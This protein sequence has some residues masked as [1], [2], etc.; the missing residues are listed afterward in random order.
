MPSQKYHHRPEA[1]S[2]SRGRCRLLLRGRNCYC[3]VIFQK[4]LFSPKSRTLCSAGQVNKRAY[5]WLIMW[6]A[7]SAVGRAAISKEICRRASARVDSASVFEL[8]RKSE[9]R[10]RIGEESIYH[11]RNRR[12][13]LRSKL[14]AASS[15]YQQAINNAVILP[16]YEAKRVKCRGNEARGSN[17]APK[18]HR[19]V[20]FKLVQNRRKLAIHQNKENVLQASNV[21]LM[22]NGSVHRSVIVRCVNAA[23][24][25]VE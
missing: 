8:V 1:P 20:Y 10:R 9:K 23:H 25:G 11:G 13:Y 7:S 5:C 14:H 3:R 16:Y 2:A 18:C 21:P 19:I 24:H 12:E 15:A 17:L 6:A 4:K 22:K